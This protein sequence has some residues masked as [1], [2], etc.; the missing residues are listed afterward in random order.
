MDEPFRRLVERVAAFYI[1]DKAMKEAQQRAVSAVEAGAADER[2]RAAYTA[3]VRR[4]FASFER[5]A[6][7]HLRTVDKRLEQ[8]NQVQ[9]NLTAERGVAVRRIEETRAVLEDLQ[10]VEDAS[11]R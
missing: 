7:A 11:A 5:E 2:A 10:R 1:T 6:R 3:A 4:Y 8:A 9:F